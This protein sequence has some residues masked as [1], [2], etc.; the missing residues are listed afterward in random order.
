MPAVDR[1]HFGRDGQSV[2]LAARFAKAGHAEQQ[3]RTSPERFATIPTVAANHGDLGT[4]IAGRP[5]WISRGSRYSLELRWP[6]P[7]LRAAVAGGAAG[8]GAVPAGAD[9]PAGGCPSSA[10][11]AGPAAD[12]DCLPG[13]IC[14]GPRHSTWIQEPAHRPPREPACFFRRDLSAVGLAQQLDRCW[15]RTIQKKATPIVIR[16][17]RSP[18]LVPKCRAPQATEMPASPPPRHAGSAPRGSETRQ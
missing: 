7:Y 9:P 10:F 1:A 14:R 11:V 15:H 8:F 2:I 18:A 17:N 12:E 6:A 4:L 13:G 16:V 5:I 3:E